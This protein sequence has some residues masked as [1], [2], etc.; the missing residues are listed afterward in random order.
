MPLKPA[1]I[2]DRD[3]TLIVD[4]VY[5]NEPDRIEY[6]P[7]VFQALRLLRDAGYVL[8]V[9]TNQS[10]VPRGRVDVRNLDEIHRRIQAKFASEGVDIL[11]FHS[12]PYMTDND[13][14]LRK[15]NPGMLLE[16]ARWHGLDLK[17]SWMVGDRM[18]DVEAGH[19]AGSR[20][21]LLGTWDSPKNSPFDPPE[22]HAPNLL[23][24]AMEIIARG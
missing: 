24:A 7:G 18:T 5:L 16:A 11:S 4:L 3:G 10:G 22:I 12:A 8:C 13:H 1:V 23:T 15:P 9:A 2:L 14:I 21:V 6:L 19:R 20:S 17:R